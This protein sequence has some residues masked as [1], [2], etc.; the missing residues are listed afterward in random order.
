M[1]TKAAKEGA[2]NGVLVRKEK[3]RVR[4][5]GSEL[6]VKANRLVEASY[7]LHLVE[8][9][10]V[11]YAIHVG[12][13]ED[14]ILSRDSIPI[15]VGAFGKKFGIDPS[16]VYR[17]VQAAAESLYGRTIVIRDIHPKSGKPRTVKTRW[18][19][20]VSYVP[21][22]GLVEL[23]FAP[24]VIPYITRLEDRYTQYELANIAGM[25]SSHAIRMYEL[26]VQY[27]GIGFREI[28]LAAFKQQLGIDG[29]YK[30]IKDL[31]R[32]VIDVGLAQIN[33]HSDLE[34]EF[35]QRKTGRA[36]T[37]LTFKIKHKPKPEPE[38]KQAKAKASPAPH[39]GPIDRAYIERHADVGESY[40]AA[41][42]RLSRKRDLELRKEREAT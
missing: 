40:E 12:R 18:V 14:L 9:Q 6:V 16:H 24:K 23:T 34:V 41:R 33:E 32:W 20:D 8:Q 21:G 3:G 10:L 29:E 13:E 2:P 7:K 36:V 42:V 19:S 1:A 37:H 4:G 5:G 39:R 28:E 25:T 31:K 27:V 17:D 26:C 38:Q 15:E 35:G 22:A 30:A 11:L